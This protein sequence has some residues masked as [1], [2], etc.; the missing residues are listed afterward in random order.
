M[1]VV[2]IHLLQH[3]IFPDLAGGR[4]LASCLKLIALEHPLTYAIAVG[5]AYEV[6][7]ARG[8]VFCRGTRTEVVVNHIGT[9]VSVAALIILTTIETIGLAPV[10]DDVVDE[11]I[12]NMTVVGAGTYTIETRCTVVAVGDETMVH[13][14][15][16]ATPLGCV[17][18]GTL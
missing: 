17:G 18:T 8:I 14:T 9:V 7:T 1:Q 15:M 6:A 5:G 10:E 11:L 2:G 4:P 3:L 16:L 12:I 13:R